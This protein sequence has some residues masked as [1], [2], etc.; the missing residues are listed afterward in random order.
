[1]SG[2]NSVKL[3]RSSIAAAIQNVQNGNKEV[4]IWDHVVRGLHIRVFPKNANWYLHYRD[5][6]R[7]EH[8]PKLGRYPEMSLED[9]R[10]VAAEA[11]KR[12]AL[13]DDPFVK[14]ERKESVRVSDVMEA[15]AARVGTDRKTKILG[16]TYIL[17]G[18]GRRDVESLR[19]EDLKSFYD[20]LKNRAF[21]GQK[22]GPPAKAFAVRVIAELISALHWGKREGGFVYTITQDLTDFNKDTIH[23]RRRRGSPEELQRLS[24]ALDKLAETMPDVAA[25]FYCLILTG[26]RVGELRT[27]KREWLSANDVLIL[28]AHK[29]DKV[30]GDKEIP[31]PPQALALIRNVETG[32]YLFGRRSHQSLHEIW[33]KVRAEAECP[34]LQLR[35]LR[36]TF[37]S[38][39]LDSGTPLEH[40]GELFGHTSITTTKGYAYLLQDRKRVTATTTAEALWK[41]MREKV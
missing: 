21:P 2:T 27:A 34:D 20:K 24:L 4:A 3:T 5:K 1:M 30:I 37:A 9:A 16:L 6:S 28:K 15:F 26:A 12:I 41:Q 33:A 8:R 32:P 17:K 31:L 39:A 23:R 18:L 35:D 7:T 10:G 22:D 19:T 38:V 40:I 11:K 29:T 13:G 25:L 36:R 14:T